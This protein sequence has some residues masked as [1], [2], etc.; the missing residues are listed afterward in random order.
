MERAIDTEVIHVKAKLSNQRE[1]E[2]QSHENDI[3]TSSRHKCLN[4][5]TKT[6][7][8][9]LHLADTNCLHSGIEIYN[10]IGYNEQTAQA[11]YHNISSSRHGSRQGQYTKPTPQSEKTV[12]QKPTAAEN[13]F[14]H[15]SSRRETQKTLSIQRQSRQ[16]TQPNSIYNNKINGINDTSN[17]TT[18]TQPQATNKKLTM[19]TPDPPSGSEPS[20]RRVQRFKRGGHQSQ[21]GI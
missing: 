20:R 21:L 16:N 11:T 10:V 2:N 9:N 4:K 3:H 8:N 15:N 13:K 19:S 6:N 5:T 14:K 7:T 18:S 1:T 12:G 17:S